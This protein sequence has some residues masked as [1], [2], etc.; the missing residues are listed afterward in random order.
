MGRK[1]GLVSIL[2]CGVILSTAGCGTKPYD[3]SSE[4]QEKVAAYAAHV[5]TRYND[6]QNEGL[7]RLQPEDVLEE[8]DADS[9]NQPDESESDQ[10]KQADSSK[11][12]NTKSDAE[13]QKTATVS[14]KQALQLE[15]GLDASFESYDV[16]D[17]FVESDYFAMNATTG[18]TFLVL[19]INLKATGGDIDCDMLSKKLNY[20]VV[21]NGDKTVAAQTSV[22]LNDLSTYQGKIADG[23]AQECVLLFETEK[24]NVENLTSLQMKVSDG[25]TSGLVELQ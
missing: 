19:H 5:V 9:K 14:L 1:K 10:E 22:L 25:S 3:L 11:K 15:E 4:E 6:R 16:T 8:E 2:L 12:S 17:S 20:R 18:K 13:Q 7:I 23:A 21:L 24:Q